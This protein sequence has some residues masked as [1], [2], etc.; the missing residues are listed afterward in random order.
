[1]PIIIDIMHT[2]CEKDI[3]FFIHVKSLR[4]YASVVAD[5]TGVITIVK[6]IV[7]KLTYL[8][9]KL[10]STTA[11]GFTTLAIIILFA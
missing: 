8:N 4:M 2:F 11:S 3:V 5:H 6:I 7:N 10:Y 9:A 1:M